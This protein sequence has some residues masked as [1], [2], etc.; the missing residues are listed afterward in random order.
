MYTSLY[1]LVV[2]IVFNMTKHFFQQAVNTVL[3]ILCTNN[4]MLNCH[5]NE[6]AVLCSKH[7]ML[8]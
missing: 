2:F 4:V 6:L 1:T 8:L 5:R 7:Y 3:L